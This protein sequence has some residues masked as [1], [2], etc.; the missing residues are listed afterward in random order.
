MIKLKTSLAVAAGTT[1]MSLI[2]AQGQNREQK[3]IS[4]G[5]GT[6]KAD[7]SSAGPRRGVTSSRRDPSPEE[8]ARMQRITELLEQGDEAIEKGNFKLAEGILIEACKVDKG[9]F[10]HIHLARLYDRMGE[11][12][13]A[14]VNYKICLRA[15]E[16]WSSMQEDARLL[17]RYGDLCVN[18]GDTDE[19]MQ[20]Y[21]VASRQSNNTV[22]PDE[23][24]PELRNMSLSTLKSS[25]HLAAA[26]RDGSHG[27]FDSELRELQ[28]S[29][30]A[31]SANWVTHYYL[32]RDWARRRRYDE[33]KR[34]VSLLKR[35]APRDRADQVNSMI[36]I[37]G[38]GNVLATPPAATRR[39]ET[40]H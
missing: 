28:I 5:T 1:L 6:L 12:K 35:L 30:K 11:Y 39:P 8:A 14:L 2:L 7:S 34:E 36:Q 40:S 9:P 19:A 22:G 24:K 32:T 29:E 15:T 27:N 4:P 31:D 3:Q 13:A 21:A 16:G 18:F 37:Q 23:P 17:A 38:L 20:A 26:L 10:I 33:A 25:A